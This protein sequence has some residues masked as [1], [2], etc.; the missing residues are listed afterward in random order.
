MK[1]YTKITALTLVLIFMMTIIS[2][3]TEHPPVVDNADLLSA[4]EETALTE[5]IEA[6]RENQKFDI[7]IVTVPFYEEA[8]VNA[9]C[10]DY[11]DYN[12]YGIGIEHDGAIFYIASEEREYAISTT[13][14]GITAITDDALSY[15][16]DEMLPDLG[17]DNYY[18]AF[19]T[20][21]NM[22][23]KFVIQAG[24]GKPYAAEEER[25]IVPV[26]FNILI[27]LIIGFLCAYFMAASKRKAMISVSEQDS[28]CQY[29]CE[30][31]MKLTA[32]ND[33]FVNT[34]VT[35]RIIEED[36]NNSGS[37]TSIGSSGT[38]H[39]GTSGRF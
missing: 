35:T 10:Q 31:S 23:Q 25:D 1:K 30:G 24:E 14:Y 27:A 12:G 17:E 7:V 3:G 11:Y 19:T 13:G 34:F 28:A 2:Y 21:V 26:L 38:T 9:A 29:T 5:A 4:E 39:G 22:T 18:S 15:M 20:F 8:D 37:T 16:E 33:I 6:V 36:D 32:R